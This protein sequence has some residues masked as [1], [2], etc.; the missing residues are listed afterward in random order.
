M[1]VVEII[2]K[3]E[4]HLCDIAREILL[5]VQ[6]I[7]PFELRQTKIR[8]GDGLYAMYAERVPVI[9]VNGE[10]AF[11]FRVRQDE[12]LEKLRSLEG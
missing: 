9:L 3:E 8:E 12:M 10:A 2:S 5:K 4:C 11:Q 6:K 7:S 1:T